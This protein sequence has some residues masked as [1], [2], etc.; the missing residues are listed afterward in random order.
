MRHINKQANIIFIQLFDGARVYAGSFDFCQPFHLLQWLSLKCA[1]ITFTPPHTL[2]PTRLGKEKVLEPFH[3]PTQA[4]RLV[5]SST[6]L[7]IDNKVANRSS[8]NLRWNAQESL[9]CFLKIH[10]HRHTHT[11]AHIYTYVHTEMESL[12]KEKSCSKWKIA[13]QPAGKVSASTCIAVCWSV[14]ELLTN[15]IDRPYWLLIFSFLTSCFCCCKASAASWY[16]LNAQNFATND[17]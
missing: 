11:Y 12:V 7:N 17:R 5:S 14:S 9:R 8:E 10:T 3:S 15:G 4:A 13:W 16:V 1:Q 6:C 2:T